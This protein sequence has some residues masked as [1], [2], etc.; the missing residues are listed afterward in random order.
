M[1][2]PLDKPQM[3]LIPSRDAQNVY[4]LAIHECRLLPPKTNLR[5][6]RAARSQTQ[7]KGFRP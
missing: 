4:K 3:L 7:T 1:N 2:W 6:R 5:A